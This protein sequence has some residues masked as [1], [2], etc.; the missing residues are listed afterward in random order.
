MQFHR[1][2]FC[3]GEFELMPSAN[4]LSSDDIDALIVGEGL[5]GL[6]PAGVVHGGECRRASPLQAKETADARTDGPKLVATVLAPPPDG[7][8]R[9]TVRALAAA[10]GIGGVDDARHLRLHRAV[11]REKGK[12]LQMGGKPGITRRRPPKRDYMIKSGH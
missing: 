7:E 6:I 12:S 8:T 5:A 9:W 11:Q 3:A 2:G 4:V 10:V 1:C